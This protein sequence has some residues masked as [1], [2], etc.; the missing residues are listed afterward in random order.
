MRK[1][2]P[3]KVK[4]PK[5]KNLMVKMSRPAFVPTDGIK[6]WG[7]AFF[8]KTECARQLGITR[9]A[10]MKMVD[11]DTHIEFC[12]VNG[13]EYYADSWVAVTK[14]KRFGQDKIRAF[15]VTIMFE[16]GIYD[17]P[18]WV[19]RPEPNWVII[20]YSEEGM[21]SL[22]R[23]FS[24]QR[25]EVT[26]E[27]I[28]AGSIYLPNNRLEYARYYFANGINCILTPFQNGDRYFINI[29]KVAK[30]K[31]QGKKLDDLKRTLG[32][33]KTDADGEITRDKIQE[34]EFFFHEQEIEER[35]EKAKTAK[36][37]TVTTSSNL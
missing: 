2:L 20:T 6:Q 36:I 18:C 7:M 5:K 31:E 22:L 9:Q 1:R 13:Q 23:Q 33:K 27:R 32:I 28:D 29:S 3:K 21:I 4:P 35:A 15:K 24:H 25:I 30:N 34:I 37:K 8:S 17:G 12:Y 14:A 26:Q 11:R 10:V 19:R 16:N